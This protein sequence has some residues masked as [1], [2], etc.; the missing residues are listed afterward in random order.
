MKLIHHSPVAVSVTRTPF[1]NTFIWT[2]KLRRWGHLL[3]IIYTRRTKTKWK[4]WFWK[5][6]CLILMYV[7]NWFKFFL[8]TGPNRKTRQGHLRQLHEALRRGTHSRPLRP[9][10]RLQILHWHGD[11]FRI[12]LDATNCDLTIWPEKYKWIFS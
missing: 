3:K 5:T 9:K 4:I 8:L 10:G 6:N 2:N 7:Q 12:A 11:Y 1:K